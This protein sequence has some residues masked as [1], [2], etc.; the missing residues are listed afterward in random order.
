MRVIFPFFFLLSINLSLAHDYWLQPRKFILSKG[1]TLVVHLY[2]GDRLKKE[3]ER[4]LQKDMTLK[5]EIFTDAKSVNLLDKSPD[6]ILPV[7]EKEVDFEGLALIAMERNYAYVELNRKEFLE[8]VKHD[9]GDKELSEIEKLMKKLPPREIEREKYTRYIKSLIVAGRIFDGDIYKKVLG[10]RLEIILL[11]NPYRLK[12]GD[13]I[14]AQILFEGKP[15]ANKTVIGYNIYQGKFFE[16]KVKTGRN[17]KVKF[18][19]KNPGLWLIRL[20]HILPCSNCSDADWESFW[21]S[22]SFEIPTSP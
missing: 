2:V 11:N 17:G 16:Y 21:A 14:E 22:F 4:E 10:Q 20:T 18:K 7:I 12:P 6:K 15:L 8:Y 19:V 9:V 1:D 3:I 13:S 5:F